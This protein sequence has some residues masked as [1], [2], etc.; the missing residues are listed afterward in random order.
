MFVFGG[1][2]QTGLCSNELLEFHFGTH[3]PTSERMRRARSWCAHLL[4]CACVQIRALGLSFRQ[5]A[6]HQASVTAM[7]LLSVR[8]AL[9]GA[10]V[11]LLYRVRPRTD[12]SLSLSISLYVCRM[13]TGSRK[14]FMFIFGGSDLQSMLSDMYRYDFGTRVLGCCWCWCWC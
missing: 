8:A 5:Q 6:H 11:V 13:Y 3:E 7:V 12:L 14:A 2:S 1:R 9:L 4:V 10:C